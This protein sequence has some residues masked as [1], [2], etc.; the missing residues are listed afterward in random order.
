[1]SLS[2]GVAFSHALAL[3]SQSIIPNN[4]VLP[5]AVIAHTSL[6]SPGLQHSLKQSDI[7]ASI[8]K[9]TMMKTCMFHSQ[10]S[11]G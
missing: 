1:M 11:T 3:G 6:E 2:V 4:T 10:Y 7:P 5:Y 9:L 8:A